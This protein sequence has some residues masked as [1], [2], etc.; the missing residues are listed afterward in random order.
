MTRQ[1]RQ[2]FGVALALVTAGALASVGCGAP[3]EGDVQQQQAAATAPPGGGDTMP[4]PNP[5]DYHATRPADKTLVVAAGSS[6]AK[7]TLSDQAGTP[8]PP[9]TIWPTCT[10]WVI[11][12]VLPSNA[13]P[14]C[15]DQPCLFEVLTG[16]GQAPGWVSEKF[17]DEFY[18]PDET[19]GE[20]YCKS[21]RRSVAV[22]RK[23]AGASTFT[24]V[25][26]FDYRGRWVNGSECQVSDLS[27]GQIWDTSEVYTTAVPPASG[28]NVYRI[29]ESAQV[30]GVYLS[31]VVAAEH[32]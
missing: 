23:L 4:L 26:T 15:G 22:Y 11:D 20:T 30:N 32:E 19:A 24:K 27:H 9:P 17:E 13:G 10:R 3:D 7:T 18:I 5:C 1:L 8:V 6:F 16:A 29:V 31:L 12:V 21:Y 14:N 25:N 2:G 28:Q